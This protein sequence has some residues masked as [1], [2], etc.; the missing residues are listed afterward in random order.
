MQLDNQIDQNADISKDLSLW[1]SGGSSITRSMTIVPVNNILIYV[2]PI[3]LA[4]I[5]ESQIP[6]IKKV[7]VSNGVDLAMATTFEEALA[8]L[9]NEDTIQ[10]TVENTDTV[11]DIVDNLITTNRN[12]KQ[13][14]NE[15]NWEQY[16]KYMQK[17]DDLIKQLEDME[18]SKE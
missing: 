7:V 1:N 10:I 3:Y 5:N 4:A 18:K 16:G 8:K 15:A 9:I 2:E 6:S 11:K 17:I 14:A 12:L 13:A